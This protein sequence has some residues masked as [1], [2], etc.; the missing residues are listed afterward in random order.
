[1]SNNVNLLNQLINLD[2][3]LYDT[4]IFSDLLT[5]YGRSHADERLGAF[6][7]PQVVYGVNEI[8]LWFKN[9][10]MVISYSDVE[11]W[12]K[13]NRSETYNKTVD[14]LTALYDL[15]RVK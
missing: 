11:Q 3:V 5:D 12:A 15:Q 2:D 10:N 1:M 7:Y 13:A 9:Y 6:L 14:R 4:K 8:C